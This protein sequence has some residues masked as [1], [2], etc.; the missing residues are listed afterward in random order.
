MIGTLS[1]L[2]Y[3]PFAEIL[4]NEFFHLKEQFALDK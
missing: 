1:R 4:S 3:P 2:G